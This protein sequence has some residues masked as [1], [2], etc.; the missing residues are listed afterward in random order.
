MDYLL[1]FRLTALPVRS[2]QFSA[3]DI[4]TVKVFGSVFL[5]KSGKFIQ[6]RDRQYRHSSPHFAM[7]HSIYAGGVGYCLFSLRFYQ[8]L[9]GDKLWLHTFFV[10]PSTESRA[11]YSYGIVVKYVEF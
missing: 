11:A 4:Q 10:Q 8:N 6:G 9:S 2:G 3:C 7:Y 5:D 1:G